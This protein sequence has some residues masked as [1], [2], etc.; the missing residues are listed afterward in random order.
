MER[1]TAMIRDL[2]LAYIIIV[3]IVFI[4]WAIFG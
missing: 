1:R 2:I 3:V 4:I